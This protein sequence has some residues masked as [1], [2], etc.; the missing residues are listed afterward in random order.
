[1]AGLTKTKSDSLPAHNL[2]RDPKDL[3]VW[4][5]DNAG[6]IEICRQN[7]Y[8]TVYNDVSASFWT[9]FNQIGS[10]TAGGNTDT[11]YTLLNIAN[12]TKP[13]IIGGVLSKYANHSGNP[14]VTTE[15]TVDGIVTEVVHTQT[16][17]LK[18]RTWIGFINNEGISQGSGAYTGKGLRFFGGASNSNDPLGQYGYVELEQK[19]SIEDPMDVYTRGWGPLLYAEHSIM[20]R[21]KQTHLYNAQYWYSH[22]VTWRYL[23][24]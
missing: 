10:S 4:G 3:P 17:N 16:S 13:I 6:F 5:T 22:G 19:A 23:L 9:T 15:F 2:T 8:G 21:Q 18:G 20:I 14:V 1:M 11:W 24:A 12:A 7:Y